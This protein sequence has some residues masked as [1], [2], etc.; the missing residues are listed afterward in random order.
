MTSLE[1]VAASARS[2]FA[3][4]FS[5]SEEYEAA[6]I[7]ERRALGRYRRPYRWTMLT[8]WGVAAAIACI[9]LLAVAG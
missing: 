6:L 7:C 5:T 2:G 9:V 3:C 8:F 1:E 4:L